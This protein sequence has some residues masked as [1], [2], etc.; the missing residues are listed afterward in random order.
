[1]EPKY[2]KD[3]LVIILTALEGLK[4]RMLQY[5]LIW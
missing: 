3:D 4:Q 1:M 2:T 5:N